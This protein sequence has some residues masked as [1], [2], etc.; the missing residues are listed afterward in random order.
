MM[1]QM[2]CMHDYDS[3]LLYC[4]MVIIALILI[5]VTCINM[6]CYDLAVI[7]IWTLMYLYLCI[8]VPT[9]TLKFLIYT[10]WFYPP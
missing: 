5:F 1:F 3:A 9:L 7:I 10:Y 4:A 2:D 6:W 8:D